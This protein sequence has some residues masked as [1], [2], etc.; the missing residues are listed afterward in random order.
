MPLPKELCAE[1]FSEYVFLSSMIHAH[2]EELFPGMRVRGCYQFRLTRNADMTVDPEEVSDLAS[3]L[4]AACQA[5]RS[6]RTSG[7]GR[8]LSG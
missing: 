8:Q 5:L 6:R 2:A 1:G 4:R 3:A 7:S